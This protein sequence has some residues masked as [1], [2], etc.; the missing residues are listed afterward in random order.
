MQISAIIITYNEEFHIEAC[1]NSLLPIADEI[2]VL[3]SYSTDKTAE[4]CKQF[5]QVIFHQQYFKGYGQQ[6]NDA[7]KWCNGDYIICLDADERLSSGL[8]DEILQL[9]KD[10]PSF[11]I[12]KIPRLNNYYGHWMKYGGEY[13]DYK[14]RFWKKG[15]AIWSEAKVHESLEFKEISS[16]GILK[17][18]ILHYT[19]SSIFTHLAQV[20]KFSELAAERLL[21]LNKR[22]SVLLKIILTPPFTFLKK[23]IFQLGFLDG[24]EGFTVAIISAHSKF[25]KYAK[26]MQKRR[27]KHQ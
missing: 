11:E 24:F 13:P 16:I 10:K 12:Y 6:K 1:I 8:I 27:T 9:I 14:I 3:D 21:N 7:V 22:K 4:I 15:I 23:Y 18:N 19:T 5:K 2:I 26:Y 25:L 20:N 17:N